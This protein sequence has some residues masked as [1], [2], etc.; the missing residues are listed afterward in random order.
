LLQLSNLFLFNQEEEAAEEEKEKEDESTMDTVDDDGKK[1][2]ETDVQY[3]QRILGPAYHDH[4]VETLRQQEEVAK[5]LGKGKRI[6]KQI[7]YAEQEMMAAAIE[8]GKVQ[9]S[10]YIDDVFNLSV[11]VRIYYDVESHLDEAGD[12][13]RN[14]L[15]VDK[16]QLH[17][18]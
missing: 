6:R 15:D 12:L 10:M 11:T 4:V 16:Q 14:A 5:T 13:F 1:A 18:Y 9:A 2:T 3:W 17:F 8:G 7:N